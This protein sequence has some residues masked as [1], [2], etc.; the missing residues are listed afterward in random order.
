MARVDIEHRAHSAASPANVFAL[1][2]NGST[3]P[4]W[5]PF[6]SFVLERPGAG[7]PQGVGAIRELRT[8]ISRVHEEIT[9]FEPDR[10]V[11]YR[12]LS[13]MPLRDYEAETLLTP[14][15]GGTDIVWRSHFEPERFA[16]FWRWLMR[17]VIARIAND[18]ARAAERG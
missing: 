3:W 6:T 13:G 17:R 5:S 11:S 10:R 16:F 9:G 4:S 8:R 12:L 14:R 2:S 1:L 7:N 18:L 15:D